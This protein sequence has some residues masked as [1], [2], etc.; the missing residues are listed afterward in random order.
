LVEVQTVQ[1]S[2]P[3]GSVLGDGLDVVE[4]RQVPINGEQRFTIKHLPDDVAGF[5]NDA[6]VV[7]D[8][9]VPDAAAVQ[10]RRTIEAAAA[11]RGVKE[12]RLIDSIKKLIDQGAV[13]KEFEHVLHYVRKLGNIGAHYRDE[14][15]STEDIERALNFTAQL[16]RNLFEVPGELAQLANMG[17]V[18]TPDEG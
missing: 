15:L 4:V 2:L 5:F 12:G 9:G 17:P 13:T 14:K 1:D 10:L 11:H 8:A 18:P 7:L 16:L 3:V 6:S